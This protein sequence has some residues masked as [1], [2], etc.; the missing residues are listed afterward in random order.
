MRK[1]TG[2]QMK[3]SLEIAMSAIERIK[4]YMDRAQ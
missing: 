2:K 3:R 1:L 4:K